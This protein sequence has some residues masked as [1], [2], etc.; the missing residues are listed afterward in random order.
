MVIFCFLDVSSNVVTVTTKFI[1]CVHVLGLVK[2]GFIICG[3]M[4]VFL[5]NQKKKYNLPGYI[6]RPPLYK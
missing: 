1:E 4:T 3:T 6:F 2:R 5:S